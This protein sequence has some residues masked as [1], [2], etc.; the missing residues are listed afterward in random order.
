MFLLAPE[1]SEPMTAF[2]TLLR[3]PTA[4]LPLL[5]SSAALMLVVV[6]LARYGVTHDVDEGT[7][8]H[9]FQLLMA[10]QLPIVFAFAIKW[11]PSARAS[12]VRVLI[13]QVLAILAAFAPVAYFEL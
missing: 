3:K 8:A 11:L 12:A 7:S 1:R 4:Y 9:L 10:A 13:L 6:H 5:M 2:S